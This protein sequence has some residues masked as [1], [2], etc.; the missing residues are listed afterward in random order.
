M[1][2]PATHAE[3]RG[4]LGHGM[5]SRR[6]RIAKDG[7]VTYY[8]SKSD[9]DRS[10]DYWHEAGHVDLYGVDDDGRVHNDR[11]GPGRPIEGQERRE[12]YN[13]MLEPRLKAKAEEIGKGNFSAGVARAIEGFSD[14]Q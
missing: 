7:V 6:V 14:N 13:V 3:I 1:S 12:R 11:R 10:H 9:T 4:F 2:R 5:G 8:G